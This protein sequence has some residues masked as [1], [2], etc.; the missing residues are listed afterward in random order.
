MNII[1]ALVAHHDELRSLYARA[2]ADPAAFDE[3]TRHLGVHHTMEEKYFY[4]FLVKV[5]D[6]EAEAQ[7]GVNE[8]QII[9]MIMLD[10]KRFPRDHALFPVK[11][12]GLGEYTNHHLE[13]EETVVF[14]LAR[15][16]LP[17]SDQ[18]RLGGLFVQAKDALLGVVL[19]EPAG[20]AG[21]REGRKKPAKGS[22][23]PPASGSSGLGIGSLK[24]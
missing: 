7:D 1:D 6:A 22:G 13:D 9:E 2:E 11:V 8:H 19:P 16:T 21:A 3:Y 10:S 23:T 4:D 5:Q 18:E 20:A 17:A 14:P 24:E 15:R 12:E